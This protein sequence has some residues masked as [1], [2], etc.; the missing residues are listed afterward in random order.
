MCFGVVH[1]SFFIIIAGGDVVDLNSSSEW[2]SSSPCALFL[3]LGTNCGK[4]RNIKSQRV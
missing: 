2:Y 4:I 3:V 1:S